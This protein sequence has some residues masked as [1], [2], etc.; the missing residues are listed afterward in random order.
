MG[1]GSVT[2]VKT[3]WAAL[4]PDAEQVAALF[5]ERLFT[6]YPEVRPL[7]RTDMAAQARKLARMLDATVKAL[8]DLDPAIPGIKQLGADH[9]GYGVSEEDYDKVGDA[10]L[11]ALAHGLGDAF[12]PDVDSA[13]RAVYAA[14]AATMKAGATEHRLT[15]AA[16]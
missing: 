12:T 4:E 16:R 1:S 13:W 11:W 10:L 3:T 9:A 15:G 2:L 7:F 8:D 6:V 5:Y 14:L